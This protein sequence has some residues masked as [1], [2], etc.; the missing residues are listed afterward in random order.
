MQKAAFLNH[1]YSAGETGT[2]EH[3]IHLP[4]SV[5]YKNTSTAMRHAL[6]LQYKGIIFRTAVAAR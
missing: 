2:K 5:C 4:R 6:Q 1:S 3:N